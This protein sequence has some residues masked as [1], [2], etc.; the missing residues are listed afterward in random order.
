M[1]SDER[2]YERLRA[3]ELDAFD[4]L[5][6]RYRVQL[7]GFV[8][9]YLGDADAGDAFHESFLE[10]LAG[11]ALDFRRGS[12]KSWLYVV[13]RNECLNR[14]RKRERATRANVRLVVADAP[15]TA[16]DEALDARAAEAALR[17]AV[18]KLPPPLADLF[19]LRTAGLSYDEM[20]RALSVPVGTVKSRMHEMVEQLKKEMRPWSAS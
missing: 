3:G 7:Y 13:A 4:G 19:R 11:R 15:S 5:Y 14:L 1:E 6:A 17:E 8:R 10:V 18:A 2:L 20:A 16:A 12:F 9:S